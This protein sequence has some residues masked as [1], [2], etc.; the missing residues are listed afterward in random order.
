M[1]KLH[2]V[3]HAKSSWE[4]P[5]LDDIERPLNRRGVASCALMG[6]AIAAAGCDFSN[7]FCS[8]ALR[9]QATLAGLRDSLPTLDIQWLTVDDLY[10]F[11]SNSLYQWFEEC[12][13]DRAAISSGQSQAGFDELVIVGHNPALTD[14]CN[15]LS[16]AKLTNIPTCAYAQL[17]TH[18]S[19][20]WADIARMTFALSEFIRPKDIKH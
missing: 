12:A 15:E 5:Q 20:P 11:D 1:K 10:C 9:A 18:D 4:D 3:R 8:P 19:R 14:L 13:P 2:L 6:P 7:T 16:D 17:T